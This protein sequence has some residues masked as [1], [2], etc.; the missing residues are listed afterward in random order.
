M[1]FYDN[2]LD[3]ILGIFLFFLNVERSK[4]LAGGQ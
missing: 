2:I 1:S 3:Y 4:H